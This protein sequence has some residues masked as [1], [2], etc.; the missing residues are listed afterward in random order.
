[1]TAP[2]GSI[3]V[4]DDDGAH[5]TM[6]ATLLAGWGYRVTEA[7]DGGEAVVRTRR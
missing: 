7:P 5:R 4:V 1:M 3:L 6:L 2:R